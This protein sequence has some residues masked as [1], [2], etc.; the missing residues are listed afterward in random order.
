[1]RRRRRRR[2]MRKKSLSF[3]KHALDVF[4]TR[5]T[6]HFVLRQ[7][8]ATLLPRQTHVFACSLFLPFFCFDA[9]L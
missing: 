7:K 6:A 8:E 5:P 1:M 4:T 2:R 9:F 3:A